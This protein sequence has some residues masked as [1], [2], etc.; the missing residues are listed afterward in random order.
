[1][2][3]DKSETDYRYD[4]NI[5]KWHASRSLFMML[6]LVVFLSDKIPLLYMKFCVGACFFID[7]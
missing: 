5:N 7:P 3:S 4:R 2:K 1:M 6:S